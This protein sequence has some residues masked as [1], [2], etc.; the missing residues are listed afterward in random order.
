MKMKSILTVMAIVFA[1]AAQ[2]QTADEILAKY[3]QTT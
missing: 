3:F 1:L 2:A